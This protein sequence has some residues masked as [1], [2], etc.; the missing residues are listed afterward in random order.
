[1]EAEE[2]FLKEIAGQEAWGMDEER[3]GGR[4][5]TQRAFVFVYQ[6]EITN[7]AALH[8][9]LYVRVYTQHVNDWH[10]LLNSPL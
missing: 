9:F 6:L 5:Q 4:R 8:P 2:G 10:L 7:T 1:M 3:E